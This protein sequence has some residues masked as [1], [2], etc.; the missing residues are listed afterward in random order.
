MENEQCGLCWNLKFDNR[1][2]ATHGSENHPHDFIP[3]DFCLTCRRPQYDQFG[4]PT[5]DEKIKNLKDNPGGNTHN[6]CS[7]IK[8]KSQE[9][10]RTKKIG[11]AVITI[12][13]SSITSLGLFN[14]FF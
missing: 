2:K 5:H 6:F 10:K 7:A 8:K 9:K 11:I 12:I 13:F 3:F 4:I 14:L 1:G